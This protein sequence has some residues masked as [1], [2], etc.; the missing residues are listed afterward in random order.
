MVAIA[1]P[2]DYLKRQPAFGVA[3]ALGH[4]KI[5]FA[6]P[7]GQRLGV[8]EVAMSATFRI[9]TNTPDRVGDVV[10]SAGIF[11]RNYETNPIWLL[12]HQSEGLPIGKGRDPG[13]RL[14]VF[15][16]PEETIATCFF[17]QKTKDA[18]QVFALVA[19]DILRATSIGFNPLEQPIPRKRADANPNSIEAGM[20]FPKIDLLEIS[21]VCVPAQPQATL[22]R[23]HLSRGKIA[24][25]E[26]SE[27]LKKSLAPYAEARPATVISGW[28][29][30]AASLE[31]A[32]KADLVTFAPGVQGAVCANCEYVTAKDGGDYCE[33]PEVDQPLPDGRLRQCCSF[34]DAPGTQR[35]W[36]EEVALVKHIRHEA[37][38]P[39]GHQWVLYSHDM[40]KVL[41]THPSREAAEEQ[42][43]AVEAHKHGKAAG[44]ATPTPQPAQSPKTTSTERGEDTMSKRWKK[45]APKKKDGMGESSGTAGG[46]AVPVEK[47]EQGEHERIKEAITGVMQEHA[48]AN[49]DH[50]AHYKAET[51]EVHHTHPEG[52]DPE[53]LD[54]VKSAL[55]GIDGVSEV[56]QHHEGPAEEGYE[57]VFPHP[58]DT[59]DEEPAGDTGLQKSHR[60][61]QLAH[62]IGK[63]RAIMRMKRF[64]PKQKKDALETCVQHKIPKIAD[65][66]PEMDNDERV[67]VA[68]S[69]CGEKAFDED[70]Y[71]HK[72]DMGDGTNPM[73]DGD[74]DADD[75][76]G[77]TSDVSRPPSLELCQQAIE[78]IEAALPGLEPETREFWED[79]LGQIR[80]HGEER[81]P[82]EDFGGN[83]EEVSQEPGTYD[84]DAE[85]TEDAIEAYSMAHKN[86]KPAQQKQMKPVTKSLDEMR[87]A[88]HDETIKAVADHLHERSMKM[89]GKA[90]TATHAKEDHE[91]ARTLDHM[92]GAMN[93][94]EKA[95]A[96]EPEEEETASDA[97]E[98]PEREGETGGLFEKSGLDFGRLL[99]ELK[100]VKAAVDGIDSKLAPFN[101]KR[102]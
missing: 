29:P 72:D 61:S 85:E 15:P 81:Y 86:G 60:Q 55:K 9:T 13:G 99:K 36:K 28:Q 88:G 1:Q 53:H 39:K 5:A 34:W 76:F 4:E 82:D 64:L 101:G 84:N 80:A 65:D 54:V 67:A 41:G 45:A 25:R 17:S 49:G 58:A 96:E 16:K 35:Q 27:R 57:K 87:E 8:D 52:H 43:R 38:R 51:G 32:K 78:N 11:L 56:H 74:M 44:F 89:V 69:M 95:E 18:E 93:P 23:S 94:K 42:E 70:D 83:E 14:C 2:A 77:D 31:R 37:S 12:N 30:D 97:K 68:Y 19:E 6:D 100:P 98:K 46:Y 71:E 50:E 48:G 24:G 7:G 47:P 20:Y 3:Y 59:G 40:S 90:Y 22:L 73:G 79:I 21:I 63:G 92:Y 75:G 66:H 91:H 102:K 62:H 33:N 26:I 10:D